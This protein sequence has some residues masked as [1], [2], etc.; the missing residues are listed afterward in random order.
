VTDA[1]PAGDLREPLATFFAATALAAALYWVGRV[2]PFI[3]NNLH[4]AI[5]VIFLYA[6]A[7]AARLSGRSFDYQNAGLRASPLKLNLAVAGLGGALA[8][9]LFL[10]AFL[11]FYG[12]VCQRGAP[13]FAQLWAETFAP[14]CGRWLSWRGAHLRF[15]PEF[16]LLALSQLLVVAVPEEL[17][18]RGYL[19]T[20]LEERWPSRRRFLGAPVGATLLVTSA[21]FALGHVL[22]DLDVQRFSVFVPALIFGWMR[23]RTGSIAAGAIFHA[24]CNLLSEVLHTSFFF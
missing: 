16:P 22:V 13:A 9:P 12:F 1:D 23:A 10:A 17:F 15:P 8:F 4:G 5:A 24:S 3:Q 18:F 2:V 6:P 21:L 7:A 19:W 14:I 11:L 20:R